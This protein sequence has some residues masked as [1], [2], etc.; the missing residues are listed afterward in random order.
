MNVGIRLRGR[1]AKAS[2]GTPCGLINAAVVPRVTA[3]TKSETPSNCHTIKP[4]R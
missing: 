1:T 3:I 4:F 2:V